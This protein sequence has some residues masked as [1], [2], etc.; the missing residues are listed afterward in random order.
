MP[1]VHLLDGI[2]IL[3]ASVFHDTWN[4]FVRRSLLRFVTNINIMLIQVL[5]LL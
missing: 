4:N 5:L 3:F 2:G 1:R